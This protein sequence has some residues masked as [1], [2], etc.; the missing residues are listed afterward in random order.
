VKCPWCLL[1]LPL[2]RQ[3]RRRDPLNATAPELL[4]LLVQLRDDWFEPHYGHNDIGYAA[5]LRDKIRAAIAKA[6]G[7]PTGGGG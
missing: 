3:A 7:R 1:K 2:M 5:L 4:A 6:E